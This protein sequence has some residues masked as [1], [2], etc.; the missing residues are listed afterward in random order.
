MVCYNPELNL[1]VVKNMG[2]PINLLKSKRF[3]PL[4][5][6]QFIGAFNDNAVKNALL[7][8]YTYDV[9]IERS[10]SSPMM[11]NIAAAL[12]ILPFFLFSATAGQFA[13]CHEKSRLTRKIKIV[14]I[15]LMV[16]CAY[17]FATKGVYGLLL[18]L[19]ALGVQS[20][21][22]GPIKY[23]LLPNHLHE[24]ELVSG[25]GLIECGT[26]LA[27]LL[28]TI[29]GGLVIL[30]HNGTIIFSAGVITL[31]IIGWI[32]SLFIPKADI[33]QEDLKIGWNIGRETLQIIKY[34]KIEH[35]VWLS[36]IAISWFWAVGATFLTQFPTYTNIVVGGDE[37]IVTL[38]ITLFSVGI[39]IGSLWCNKLIKGR[40]DGSL[41]PYGALGMSI[42][43]GSF[44]YFSNLYNAQHTEFLNNLNKEIGYLLNVHDFLAVG[45]A[46]WGILC[47][48]LALT[49]SASIYIVPLYAIVQHRS[50]KKHLSRII[51]AN[52]VMNSLFMVLGSIG[53]GILLAYHLSIINVLLSVGIINIGV[54]FIVRTIV[55]RRIG[56][57]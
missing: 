16:L 25:N 1:F 31:A 8:W 56:N 15:I 39:G 44:V 37:H 36:I 46:S 4:F 52:N 14:E 3:L 47:S 26:F 17:F 33:A 43:I 13:D 29:F 5:I 11:V 23:S 28:G 18:V 35:S 57:V 27:I 45:F 53:S 10:I 24:D 30:S 7:I 42:A 20:T 6:T 40:I 34:A 51:A 19:F 48:L 41:V 9:N 54:Y 49:I 12:F 50:N 21:F 38:F 32:T 55:H 2:N 22:F